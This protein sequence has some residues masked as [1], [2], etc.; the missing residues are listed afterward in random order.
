ML[1]DFQNFFTD[2]FPSKRS[3]RNYY[4]VFHLILTVLL[5]YFAK[6]KNLK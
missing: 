1:T 2:G 3:I 4:K 5:H 6:F